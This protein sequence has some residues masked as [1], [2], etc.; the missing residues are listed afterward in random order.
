MANTGRGI[1]SLAIKD[2]GSLYASYIP[3]V[4]NG[5]L[6]IPTN[7]KFKL[8]EEVFLLLTLMEESERIPV[9]GQ[10]VWITPRSA[11]G[12]RTSGVGVQFSSQDN[13]ETKAKIEALLGGALQ[14]D[15][16]THTM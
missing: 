14:A 2:K 9:A 1:T 5:G 11:Q 10:V 8:G 3:F 15:R 6:F 7:K 16:P 13:G 12:N 4:K